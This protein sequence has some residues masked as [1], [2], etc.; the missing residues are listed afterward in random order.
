MEQKELLKIVKRTI[1]QHFSSPDSYGIHVLGITNIEAKIVD[2]SKDPFKYEVSVTLERPGLFIGR[3]G[4][5]ILDLESQ[6]ID[7]LE[8]EV[9]ILIHESTLW[10]DLY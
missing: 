7:A 9:K 10:R 3:A 1:Y 4:S 8:G 5:T 2:E 6:L